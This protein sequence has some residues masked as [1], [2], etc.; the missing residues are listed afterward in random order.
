MKKSC[1]KTLTSSNKK[2]WFYTGINSFTIFIGL[3]QLL[4]PIVLKYDNGKDYS[5]E[6]RTRL[7]KKN[8]RF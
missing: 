6:K 8:T 3:F 1:M 5:E 4:E 2:V 7:F